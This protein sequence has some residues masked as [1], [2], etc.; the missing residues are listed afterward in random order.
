MVQVKKGTF[1][2][3]CFVALLCY[4]SFPFVIGLVTD[5]LFQ[6]SCPR[7][8]VQL[9]NLNL[10]LYLYLTK[11]KQS[12]CLL[13]VRRLRSLGSH[14]HPIIAV[15]IAL[16]LEYVSCIY[17][18]WLR[19][20]GPDI[21]AGSISEL[22]KDAEE[23]SASRLRDFVHQ[24]DVFGVAAFVFQCLRCHSWVGTLAGSNL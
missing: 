4:F 2:D 22:F 21:S 12:L 14:P 19:E 5:I 15:S 7:R 9:C 23:N 3:F 24:D 16:L 20:W 13:M 6:L 8:Q 10:N 18:F 1:P 17:D 11:R